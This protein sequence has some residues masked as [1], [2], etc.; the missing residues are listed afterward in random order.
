MNLGRKLRRYFATGLKANRVAAALSPC[1]FEQLESRQ[2]L[3]AVIDVRLVG[4]GKSVNVTSV[5]QVINMEVWATIT[6]TDA[7]GANDGIQSFVGSF[8]ST[9]ITGG[10]ANGTLAAVPVT[11]FHAVASTGGTKVDLDGDGD[12]DVGSNDS[13]SPDGFFVARAGEV[14]YDSGTVS[15]ASNSF[16]VGKL[17]FTV[18]SLLSGTSTKINFRKRDGTNGALWI[19]DGQ[20][21]DG[22]AGSL[23]SGTPVVLVGSAPANPAVLSSKGVL[24]V[25]GTS[26]ADTIGLAIKGSKVKVTVGSKSQSFNTSVVKKIKVLGLDGNDKIT[27]GK[28]VIGVIVDGGAGN[29]TITGGSGNDSL[30]GGAGDDSITGGSGFD[31]L[32]G[33]AG[34][35]RLFSRD[36]FPDIVDG[37]S[38]SDSAQVDSRELLSSIETLL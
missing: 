9:N 4:G 33:G 29:D 30:A 31:T 26:G 1:L 20:G 11:P 15:G 16:K 3:S 7:D 6:G 28:G 27:V 22:D 23:T 24:T 17:S 19:E 5:G 25:T 8:L 14:Q 2:L 32:R 36:G 21:K 34:N 10:S 38:G 12:L 37:G 13:S 35:D 18:T